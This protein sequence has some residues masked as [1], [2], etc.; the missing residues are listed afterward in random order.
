[1]RRQIS[2][3]QFQLPGVP[4]IREAR[5][6]FF[7]AAQPDSQPADRFLTLAQHLCKEHRLTG[8]ILGKQRFHVSLLNLGQFDGMPSWLL[9]FARC[10]AQRVSVPIFRATF[11]RGL[12]FARTGRESPF[13]VV[14]GDLS[15]FNALFHAQ[16]AAA[17]HLGMPIKQRNFTPHMTL[18]YDAKQIAKQSIETVEWTVQEFVLIHSYVGQHRYDILGRWDLAA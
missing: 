18:L 4:P 3:A 17:R 6:N 10:T 11:S 9:D 16:C 2:P 15:G 12:S 13:V 7:L 1:M 8:R 14:G 5:D